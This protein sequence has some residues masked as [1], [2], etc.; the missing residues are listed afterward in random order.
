MCCVASYTTV[1]MIHVSVSK[2]ESGM[3]LAAPVRH[4]AIPGHVLLQA[5]YALDTHTITHLGRH[6]VKSVWIRHPGFEFLD[7]NLNGKIPESRARLYESVKRSFSG[8]A[9]KTTGAFDVIEYR[10]L[11][12][13]M[14]MSLVANEDNA[15]WAQRLVNGGGELSSHCSNVAYLSLVIGMR[16]RDYIFTQRNFYLSLSTR[17]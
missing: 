6:S 13:D 1:L 12:G 3:V 16:I 5:D 8:I 2:L 15:V 17:A 7:R 14:I 9:E 10:T 4:P 11:I